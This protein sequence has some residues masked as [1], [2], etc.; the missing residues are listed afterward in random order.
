MTETTSAP[1]EQQLAADDC[2]KLQ[3]ELQGVLAEAK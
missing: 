3:E 2:K 1:L